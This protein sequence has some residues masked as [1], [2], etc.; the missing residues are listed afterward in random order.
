MLILINSLQQ[1]AIAISATP[2]SALNNTSMHVAT[3]SI[4]LRRCAYPSYCEAETPD[5]AAG[6]D[7]QKITLAHEGYRSVQPQGIKTTAYS[8][9]VGPCV[10]RYGA[11]PLY[12]DA[13]PAR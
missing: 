2:R 8:A 3:S 1:D 13:L 10:L 4:Y 12:A 7:T 6:G 11:A 5:P 9:M